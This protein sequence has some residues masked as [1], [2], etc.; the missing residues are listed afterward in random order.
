[1]TANNSFTPTQAKMI[2]QLREENPYALMADGFESAF[3]GIYRRFNLPALAVYSYEKCIQVLMKREKMTYEEAVGS[4][5]DNV[6]GSWVGEGTPAFV[7]I[8]PVGS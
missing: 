3:L 4:F 2:E 6:L 1:M 5:D 7:Q 8:K